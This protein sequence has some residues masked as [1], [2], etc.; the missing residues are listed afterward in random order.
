MM[1][2]IPVEIIAADRAAEYKGEENRIS[3]DAE[4]VKALE[5]HRK[6]ANSNIETGEKKEL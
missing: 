5:G 1:G 3:G 2:Q 4:Q 6:R